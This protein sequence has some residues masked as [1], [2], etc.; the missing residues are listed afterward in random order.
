MADIDSYGLS[1]DNQRLFINNEEIPGVQSVDFGYSVNGSLIKYLGMNSCDL[2]PNGPYAGSISI[3]TLLLS[4]DP[5]IKY[6]AQ[7]DV[8]D[9]S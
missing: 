9:M 8:T 1:R 5:F 7:T 4:D 2:I 6:T 3:S